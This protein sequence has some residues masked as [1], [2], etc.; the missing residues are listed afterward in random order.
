MGTNVL[1]TI[2]NPVGK[3]FGLPDPLLDAI[4]PEKAQAAASVTQ[5]KG[6]TNAEAQA[7]SNAESAARARKRASLANSPRPTLINDEETERLLS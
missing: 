3:I 4:L 1:R 7:K 2:I 6:I 5:Q